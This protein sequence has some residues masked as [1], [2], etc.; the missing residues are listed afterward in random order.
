MRINSSIRENSSISSISGT[1]SQRQLPKSLNGDAPGFFSV[2]ESVE[3]EAA[4]SSHVESVE[5]S[6]FR[7][8]QILSNAVLS[9]TQSKTSRKTRECRKQTS[10][11][12]YRVEM[13]SERKGEGER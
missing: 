1:S 10:N 13:E 2:V 12:L 4:F 8:S 3:E 6:P 9:D 11:H 5:C 7:V